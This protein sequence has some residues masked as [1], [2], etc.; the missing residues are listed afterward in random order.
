M[1]KLP[2]K[3][4]EDGNDQTWPSNGGMKRNSNIRAALLK[5]G[6]VKGG[7]E[8]KEKMGPGEEGEDDEKEGAICL[9]S[10]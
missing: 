10:N 9:L 2:R 5:R 7:Q 3:M 6:G 8:K 1:S 4:S